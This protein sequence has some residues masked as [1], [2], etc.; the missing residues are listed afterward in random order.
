MGTVPDEPLRRLVGDVTQFLD[1]TFGTTPLL[2]RAD[3]L[4]PNGDGWSDLLTLDDV[5]ELL[6]TTRAPSF[7][8]VRDGRVL[9]RSTYTRSGT[10]GGVH[11]DDLPDI[12]AIH[13]QFR[14][15]A[16]IVLQGLNRSHPPIAALCRGIERRLTHA[17]QA[18]AYLTPPA[19]AGLNVHHDTHD[20]FALQLHG[21]K[22]WT[23]WQP[24]V[25]DPLPG[26]P[27]QGNVDDLGPPTVDEQLGP[28]D[29][30]YL[31]RGT[32][33]AA[34]TVDAPSLHLT[35]GV[36]STTGH[37][38]LRRV[39]QLARDEPAFR[40]ALPP[41]FARDREAT[42]RWVAGLLEEFAAWTSDLDSDEFADSLAD[43]FFT[44][45]PPLLPGQLRQLLAVNDIH[46][47]T[48]VT[49]R[50]GVTADLR[51]EDDRA[52]LR[53][54]DR[55]VR[56]PGFTAATVARLLEAD[57]LAV[58]SLDDVLED[59]HSRLVLVRRLVREG[60]LTAATGDQ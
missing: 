29:L 38:V 24:Q 57:G 39:V 21:H 9:P 13:E 4:D 8:L 41:G 18:N 48:L 11:V 54:G 28:G 45:R 25:I 30:L 36:R 27:W 58:G 10:V 17:L 6:Q 2:R 34:R 16:T 53:L 55:T 5:D 37:D 59:A 44:T 31:P 56:L 1:E 20:V 52:V 35:L 46:D 47:G 23:T 3:D 14:L 19:A 40:A 42:S 12:G 43:G 60:L 49:R 22:Q 51:V 50:P 7:R 15:G 32:P 26:Q 33:H